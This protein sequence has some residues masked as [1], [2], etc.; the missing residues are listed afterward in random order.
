ML[1]YS[2]ELGCDVWTDVH[3]ADVQWKDSHA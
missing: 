3:W 2:L 1:I